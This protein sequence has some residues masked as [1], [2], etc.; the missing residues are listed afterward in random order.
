MVIEPK[1]ILRKTLASK[2]YTRS[3]TGPNPPTIVENPEKLFRKF[4]AQPPEYE[5]STSPLLRTTSL[6][7]QL[8]SLED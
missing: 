8:I 3:N 4:K 5:T 6:H 7:A 1:C 2:R